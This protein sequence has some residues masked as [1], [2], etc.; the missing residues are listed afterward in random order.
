MIQPNRID[1]KDCGLIPPAGV[2]NGVVET[3]PTLAEELEA[4]TSQ[5]RRQA[6]SDAVTYL[7]DNALENASHDVRT[8]ICIRHNLKWVEC[9]S[10]I[11]RAQPLAQLEI[12]KKQAEQRRVREEKE[13]FDRLAAL[14]TEPVCVEKS[15]GSYNLLNLTEQQVRTVA[16]ILGASPVIDAGTFAQE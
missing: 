7:V 11:A 4:E 5:V 6:L 10:L 13:N 1:T 9:D 2:G 16:G 15:A 14:F 3:G 12:A 8:A